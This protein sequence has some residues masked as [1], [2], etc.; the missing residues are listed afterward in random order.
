[1][2]SPRAR[3]EEPQVGLGGVWDETVPFEKR[4]A[5]AILCIEH[6]EREYKTTGE[7]LHA[8]RAYLYCRRFDLTIPQ[9]VL[10][11]LDRPALKF[12]KWS[13]PHSDPPD[14]VGPAVAEALELKGPG[15]SGR[16]NVF[17]DYGKTRDWGLALRA[18]LLME[19]GTKPYL[20]FEEVAKRSGVDARTVK[21]AWKKWEEAQD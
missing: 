17:A 15:R 5:A 7:A 1:M 13:Q 18:S 19:N 14:K 11:Y 2:Y 4:R 10:Q 8:W 9:W 12:Y 20:A 3:E 16:G 21:R 6:H